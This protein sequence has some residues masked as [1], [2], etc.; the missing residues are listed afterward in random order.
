MIKEMT[1]EYDRVII[2]S[3]PIIAVTDPVILSHLVEGVVLV[4]HA[5]MTSGDLVANGIRQLRD[6]HVHILGGVLNNVKIERG[7]YYYYQYQYYYSDEG[8]K[9]KKKQRR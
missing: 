8:V 6:A 7:S 4:I 3:S 9:K 5:G 1:G 2:D